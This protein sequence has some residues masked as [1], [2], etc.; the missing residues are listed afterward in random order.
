META[1]RS[2]NGSARHSGQ[3]IEK[4]KRLS[5]QKAMDPP[6]YGRNCSSKIKKRKARPFSPSVSSFL[7]PNFPSVSSFLLRIS[8]ALFLLRCCCCRCRCCFPYG[9]LP[10]LLCGA[11]AT[12]SV[13]LGAWIFRNRS[14]SRESLEREGENER[15]EEPASGETRLQGG[16]I[17]AGR[18]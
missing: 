7:L 18:I 16:K 5:N 8:R 3:E 15:E 10:F 2:G 9:R 4:G 14:N 6:A 13:L 1:M 11:V 17:C 12:K